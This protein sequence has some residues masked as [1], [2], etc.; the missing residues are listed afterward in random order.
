MG[1]VQLNHSRQRYLETPDSTTLHTV[2]IW[3]PEPASIAQ[4][5]RKLWLMFVNTL[6]HGT[7]TERG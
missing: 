4:E 2:D 6:C 1:E 7:H 3:I 5:D